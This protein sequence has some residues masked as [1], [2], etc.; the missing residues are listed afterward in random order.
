[1][2]LHFKMQLGK[3]L[4]GPNL[5]VCV[6]IND[7]QSLNK[8][9]MSEDK[10]NSQSLEQSLID[11]S[12]G[13]D[14]FSEAELSKMAESLIADKC[15]KPARCNNVLRALRGDEWTTRDILEELPMCDQM[16]WDNSA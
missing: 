2:V 16:H 12:E 5:T 9:V 3:K 1:M 6:K 11:I 7:A 13:K 8:S 14:V 10:D 15:G 4:F